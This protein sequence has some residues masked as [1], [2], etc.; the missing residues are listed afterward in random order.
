MESQPSSSVVS[1]TL[2]A[3][4]LV[5]KRV[6]L[7]VT[8]SVAAYKAVVLARCLLT[9]GAQLRVVMTVSARQFVGSATFSALTGESVLTEMAGDSGER[10][11]ELAQWSDL[12]LV[13]PAT[14]DSLARAATGRGEDLLSALLLCA[15]CPVLCAPAMHPTMFAHP[16]VQANIVRLRELCTWDFA[17]PEYGPVASGD[18]GLGRMM[19]PERL[20]WRTAQLL[21]PEL[22]PEPNRHVGGSLNG[23]HI[24]VTAGP[25]SEAIDPVRSLTNH[26]SGK[27]GFALARQ[28][29]ARGARVTLVAGPVNLT[30][31]AGCKRVDVVSAL[32]MQAAVQSA[33]GADL[34]LA[35]ALLMCAAVSDYRPKTTNLEKQK[36]S[37]STYQLQLVANP[38]ILAEVGALRKDVWPYLLGFALETVER[39]VLIERARGKLRAKNV[40]AIVANRAQDS[41]GKDQTEAIVVTETQQMDVRG[42]KLQVADEIIEFLMGHWEPSVAPDVS[43]ARGKA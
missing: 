24:V 11:V 19:M 20:A 22:G 39:S 7:C 12:I 35:D 15:S 10:H 38:D 43:S 40:D 9:A 13:A 30:T 14:A 18:I 4:C 27:M 3:K 25:T 37:A 16:M 33:L 42:D 29:A 41:I 17:G 8:G 36:R 1:P 6:T 21:V 2:P 26:S 23:R 32:Q 34:T 31:P 5:G 28:A